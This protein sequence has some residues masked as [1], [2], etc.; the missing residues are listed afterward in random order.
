MINK[1]PDRLY[2]R[3]SD[4]KDYDRLLEKDSPFVGKEN[5]DLFIM[6]LIIGFHE[7][8]RIKLDKKEG[9][10]LLYHLND[11]E[12]SII[13]AIAVAEE[14]DLNILLDKKK[15]Y[16]IAEEYAAGGIKLLKDKVFSGGYGS[17]IKKLE[18]ELID[19]FERTKNK[20]GGNL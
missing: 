14:G 11:K 7:G 16:S 5:K 18:S 10:F 4:R 15:V 3:K 8:T 6:A 13:K 2:I 1:E 9:F 19:E 20:R 12:N 17:Y